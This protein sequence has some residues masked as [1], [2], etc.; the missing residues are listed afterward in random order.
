MTQQFLPM[1]PGGSPQPEQS[2]SA[3][4]VLG[5]PADPIAPGE[6]PGEARPPEELL[7]APVMAPPP[8][9][10]APAPDEEGL[11]EPN[12]L[13]VAGAFPASLGRALHAMSTTSA[14][15]AVGRLKSRGCFV[16]QDSRMVTPPPCL[17]ACVL[18]N[19]SRL[20]IQP[21][22][23]IGNSAQCDWPLLSRKTIA[24]RL[25]ARRRFG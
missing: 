13:F 12:A 16:G 3:L 23:F 25:R 9:M 21:S 20:Q 24:P 7:P 2:V 19:A 6:P 10:G 17:H 8:V 11:P 22:Q 1:L 15:H 18:P 14:S 4:Q 5:Q